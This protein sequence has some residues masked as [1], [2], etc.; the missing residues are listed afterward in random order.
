LQGVNQGYFNDDANSTPDNS[1]FH[2]LDSPGT[3]SSV[4]Y[5]VSFQTQTGT[6]MY[7]NRTRGDVD[8]IDFERLTSSIL[9]M[10]IAG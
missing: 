6:V 3:T 5:Q 1:Y 8:T 2:Y 10:E 4:T 7:V 9:A